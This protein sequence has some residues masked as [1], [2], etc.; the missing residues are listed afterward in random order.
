MLGHVSPTPEYLEGVDDTSFDNATRLEHSPYGYFVV[1]VA[2]GAR[3]RTGQAPKRLRCTLT[4]HGTNELWNKVGSAMLCPVTLE[5]ACLP[6]TAQG[7]GCN[8]QKNKRS[9]PKLFSYYKDPPGGLQYS[10]SHMTSCKQTCNGTNHQRGLLL[11]KRNN[12]LQGPNP[13]NPLICDT[14]PVCA[15]YNVGFVNSFVYNTV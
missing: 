1:C 4:S 3:T 6:W 5:K 15:S 11:Q 9:K 14:S 7:S 2:T 12:I 13:H 10:L 8:S